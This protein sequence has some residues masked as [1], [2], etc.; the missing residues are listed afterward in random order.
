M[1]HG[2]PNFFFPGGPHGATGNNPRY[3]GDQSDFIHDALVF[4]QDHGYRTIEVPAPAEEEWTSMVDTTA[5]NSPYAFS[6]SSYF[7]GSNIPGKPIRYLLNPMGRP[8]LLKVMA[9]VVESDYKGFLA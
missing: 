5:A 8:K 6:Q 1:C 7:Y 2:F 3:S 4:M 9:A